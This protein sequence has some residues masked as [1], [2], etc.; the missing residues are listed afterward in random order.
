MCDLGQG[1]VDPV[2]IVDHQFA[3]QHENH[4]E[5][6][7]KYQDFQDRRQP[8]RGVSLQQNFIFRQN[9]HQVISFRKHIHTGAGLVIH[10]GPEYGLFRHGFP[11]DQ[12]TGHKQI[13]SLIVIPVT[14]N[15]Q[16]FIGNDNA[17]F[18]SHMTVA[19]RADHQM[20]NI[21]LKAFRVIGHLYEAA[22]FQFDS[23]VFAQQLRIIGC[24]L[25]TLDML[26][27]RTV[28][29][30]EKLSGLFPAPHI[31]VQECGMCGSCN[32]P[33]LIDDV[34]LRN[35]MPVH[36]R[37]KSHFIHR[38]PFVNFMG[39]GSCQCQQ[40]RVRSVN[41]ILPHILDVQPQQVGRTVL[42]QARLQRP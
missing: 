17:A 20:V 22:L 36:E 33:V 28:Q 14:D 18:L 7:H 6:R 5:Q 9:R 10:I 8:D 31:I 32:N 27:F 25:I 1:A 30:A 38:C 35:I 13:L 24:W 26:R 19:G 42:G 11:V 4:N 21:P 15:I 12:D 41:N 3:D 2:D 37:R 16:V 34:N 29:Q 40:I 23:C 39:N